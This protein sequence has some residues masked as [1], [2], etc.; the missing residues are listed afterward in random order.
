MLITL[1]S[2]K[3]L[4]AYF[5]GMNSLFKFI[6]FPITFVVGFISAI[7]VICLNFETIGLAKDNKLTKGELI[8]KLYSDFDNFILYEGWTNIF[9]LIRMLIALAIYYIIFRQF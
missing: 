1:F 7:F 4:I 3:L 9:P 6:A 2:V 5:C 8:K